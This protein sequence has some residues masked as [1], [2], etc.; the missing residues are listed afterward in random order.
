MKVSDTQG[1]TTLERGNGIPKK[2]E[3]DK[4]REVWEWERRESVCEDISAPSVLTLIRMTVALARMEKEKK[5]EGKKIEK[6]F[7]HVK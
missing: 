4:R 7:F 6:S 1:G 5:G 2:R 3:V